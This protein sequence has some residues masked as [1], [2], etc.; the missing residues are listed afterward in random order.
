MK[1]LLLL[2]T[3]CAPTVEETPPDRDGDGAVAGVDCDDFDATRTPGN[4]ER[5]DG[6]DQ[7][8]DGVADN[9]AVDS[10][11]WTVDAD[12][13]GYGDDGDIVWSC[14]ALGA[15]VSVGGDCDDAD[16]EVSPGA[17]ERCDGVDTN[18]DGA[19][20]DGALD[21]PTWYADTDGDGA[22]DPGAGT[23]VCDAPAGTVSEGTDC[24]DA[25]AGIHPGAAEVCDGVDTNCDGLLD[26]GADDGTRWW[27][28]ADGDTY[29]DRWAA[30]ELDCA[31]D[32]RA[33]NAL[34]CDDDDAGRNPAAGGCGLSGVHEPGEAAVS[35]LGAAEGDQLGAAIHMADLDGDGWDELYV[36]APEHED[37]V[38]YR[39]DLV[40]G[41]E[42]LEDAS[43]TLIGE[44]T[45]GAFGAALG[46]GD[47][48]GDGAPDLVVG[49][50]DEGTV[51]STGGAAFIFP[52]P[53]TGD[54]TTS[55]AIPI[56]AASMR[57]S[58]GQSLAVVGDATGDGVADLLLGAPDY[59][60]TGRAYLV[61]G[62]VA[63][64]VALDEGITIAGWEILDRAANAVDGGDLDGDG[65]SELVIGA[66]G[67]GSVYVIPGG[68]DAAISLEDAVSVGGR[69]FAWL[70]GYDVAVV[71][72]CDGDG[73]ADLLI[74][75]PAYTGIGYS[76]GEAWIVTGPSTTNRLLPLGA[77]A[78]FTGTEGDL[79][80][81][82]VAG[83][84]L[85][86]DATPE[87][88]ISAIEED[89]GGDNAGAVYVWSGPS[90][91]TW[92]LEDAPAIL[93]GHTADT[94]LGGMLATGDL[95]GDGR[96]ELGVSAPGDG[97]SGGDA[98]ATFIFWGG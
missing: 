11:P 34:D 67:A 31:A 54:L 17:P 37:G 70:T 74:G 53:I 84:D 94:Q 7:D 68:L 64:G 72:D 26:A 46:A 18:C 81:W 98:G 9:D 24:D 6:V 59:G 48:D 12:G 76:P 95:D 92:E 38:V 83:G 86:G 4:T 71:P 77:W 45:G 25:D 28:D 3:A 22:G 73:L 30:A 33:D 13:D 14:V 89:A 82:S 87:I 79:A 49:S 19:A 60:S 10:L 63:P 93:L 80:G 44:Y 32:G 78:T 61:P 66:P 50:P 40:R 56:Y 5:C 65:V 15:R 96:M 90:A 2:F 69:G 57:D 27:P 42:A 41:G 20:D 43:E 58:V 75:G 29:G 91:G 97:V 1:L 16:P 52:G 36:G 88:V 35:L 85:N 47:L 39:F 51:G 55:S 21:A 8:C 23:A 62:P